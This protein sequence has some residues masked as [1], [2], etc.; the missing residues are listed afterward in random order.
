VKALLRA[1]PLLQ[2]LGVSL[3]CTAADASPMLRNAPPFEALRIKKLDVENGNSGMLQ[4]ADAVVS[5]A[6]DVA[7]HASLTELQLQ[8][9]PLGSPAALDAFV[10]AALERRLSSLSFWCCDHNA[11]RWRACLAATRC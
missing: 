6:A 3:R 8:S 1:A 9:V 5:F 7:A 2:L 10:D 4:D 11:R